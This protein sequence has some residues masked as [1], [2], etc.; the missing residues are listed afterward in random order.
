MKT[1][2]LKCLIMLSLAIV[3]GITTAQQ[4][5]ELD[6]TSIVPIDD[7]PETLAK[8]KKRDA[9]LQKT[10]DGV[11]Y[12]DL[13][14]EERG[15]L[16]ELGGETVGDRWTLVG[17]GCSWYCGGGPQKITGSSFLKS[18]GEISYEPKN[19]HDFSAKNAWV[20]G[21]E[22]NGIG[23]Y[24]MYEF[25]G[26]SPRITELILVNGYAKSTKAYYD[27]ARA[28]KIKMYVGDKPYAILNLHDVIGKQFFDL[29]TLG[30]RVSDLNWIITFEILEVYE[31]DKYDDLAIS[32]IY[33]DGI[34]VH[35]FAKGSKVLMANGT[36]KNIED[37]QI[38]DS[39][40]GYDFKNREAYHLEVQ[41]MESQ[42]HH[43]L[44]KYTF[45][46]GNEITCTQD[47]PF[48]VV[49]KGWSSL[50]PENSKMYQGFENAGKIEIGDNFVAF[51]GSDQLV[52]IEYL[53]DHLPTYTISAVSKGDNFIVEG[54]VVGV[55]NTSLEYLA[56]S[57]SKEVDY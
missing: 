10:F 34:D 12:D 27:N 43:G 33:F 42:I 23:E 21:V 24:L 36:E 22:G 5:K 29:D 40:K 17:E 25:A 18:N 28:K 38:G 6:P 20:E 53:Q 35:C 39:V 56:T 11:K 31:G 4:L 8:W 55:E 1:N 30:G 44:V 13:T 7:S 54:M 26:N 41:K 2:L 50:A 3:T 14:Q 57:K 37:V 19:A 47:H 49:A 46:S 15:L 32:E 52:S 48:L 51:N 9:A 45:Q 16:D